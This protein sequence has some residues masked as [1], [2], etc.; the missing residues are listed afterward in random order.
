[1]GD[2]AAAG[3]VVV[4]HPGAEL[5][6]SDRM[7]LEA[8]AGLAERGWHVVLVVPGE[9]PLTVEAGR[10]G[11][12]TTVLD[13]PVLRKSLLRPRALLGFA[14]SSVVGAVR[15]AAL[16]RRV[17]P[18]AVYVATVT[19]PLW[20]LVARLLR[21]P[22]VCHVHESE[23][24]ASRLVRRMLA[25]PVALATLV[26]V[27]S[28]HSMTALVEAAPQLADRAIVLYNGVAGPEAMV[29]PRKR[30]DGDFRLVYTGRISP[31]KGVDT[32]VE[33]LALL[34]EDGVDARLEVVGGVFPGYEWFLESLHRRIDELGLQSRVR[35]A[36]FRPEVWSALSAA[37]M[38]LVPS[39]D[40]EPFGNTAVEAVLSGRPVAVSAIGGLAEAIDGFASAIPVAPADP[41]ELA[42]AIRRVSSSWA[43]FRTTAIAMAPIAAARFSPERFRAAIDD[44]MR[45][46]ITPAAARR[47]VPLR[48][49]TV[50]APAPAP[51]VDVR[52]EGA[53]PLLAAT[54]VPDG[55]E[56]PAPR[57]AGT[58]GLR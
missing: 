45:R 2:R 27:N 46:A 16:L 18:D 51:L 25:A 19:I 55:L 54:E 28:R 9:G 31:R 53:S 23:R 44:E 12:T 30:I 3:T 26:L 34:I 49:R 35:F 41:A 15:I 50:P 32:A 52:A 8:V 7:T 39:R 20:I 10:V 37:D 17:R 33:A 42:A 22:V 21:I 36:G 4:A 56:A 6:G 48:R 57:P 29:P 1:V 24:S 58:G 47:P 40:E 5:Y 11:A 13:I 38:A 14:G 43:A